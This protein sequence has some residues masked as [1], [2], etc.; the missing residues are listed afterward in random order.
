VQGCP[1]KIRVYSE[2][3]FYQAFVVCT[4]YMLLSFIIV[5]STAFHG[6]CDFPGFLRVILAHRRHL[7]AI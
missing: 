3:S 5:A 6:V 1:S 4:I 2:P 7:Q